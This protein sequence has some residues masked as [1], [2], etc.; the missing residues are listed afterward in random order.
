MFDIK[1]DTTAIL[2][3][4]ADKRQECWKTG[5]FLIR[6]IE[7][8]GSFATIEYSSQFMTAPFEEDDMLGRRFDTEMQPLTDFIHEYGPDG[9][10]ALS[11]YV[12]DEKVDA[13][14]REQALN[15]LAANGLKMSLEIDVG[16]STDL[17]GES[18]HFL[19]VGFED[20]KEL[21]VFVTTFGALS[22]GEIVDYGNA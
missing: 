15:V 5:E 18:A 14:E 11:C 17:V 7:R 8:A 21:F 20:P 2:S 9:Y 19:L 22:T 3:R 12:V 10:N 6:V 16:M 13:A 1:T 4:I